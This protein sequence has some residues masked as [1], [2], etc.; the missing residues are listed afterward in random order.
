MLLSFLLF[1]EF[2]F[3]T[4]FICLPSLQREEEEGE[5]AKEEEE[6]KEKKHTNSKS[7]L[8]FSSNKLILV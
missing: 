2:L 5:K 4:G 8:V 1:F 7:H 6:G 3:W